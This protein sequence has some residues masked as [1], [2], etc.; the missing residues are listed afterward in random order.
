MSAIKNEIGNVYGRLTVITEDGRDARGRVKWRCRCECGNSIS[1]SGTRFRSGIYQS[2]GCGKRDRFKITDETGKR[3]GKLRVIGRATKR[4]GVWECVCD[5]GNTIV[6]RGA[7]LRKT[8]SGRRSC[9]CNAQSGSGSMF[10]GGVGEISGRYW[11]NIKA[12]ARNRGHDFDI[13][14]EYMWGLFQQQQG[15]CAISGVP[16]RLGLDVSKVGKTASIDRINNSL[17]YIPGNVHWVHVDVNLMKQKLELEGF[18][19]WCRVIVSHNS[20]NHK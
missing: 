6:V 16:I 10:W 13:T 12:G 17:G 18:L 7:E 9:G 5:C 15:R 20:N 3:Y 1:L 8:R 4:I 11:S 14:M 19:E 2:C